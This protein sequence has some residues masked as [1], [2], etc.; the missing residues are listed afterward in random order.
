[1][2]TLLEHGTLRAPLGQSQEVRALEANACLSQRLSQSRSAHLPGNRVGVRMQDKS[3][4][5]EAEDFALA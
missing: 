2:T 3:G 4:G 5:A 1:M